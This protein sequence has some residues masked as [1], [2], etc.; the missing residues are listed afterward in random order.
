M[1]NRAIGERCESFRHFTLES[2]G[3]NYTQGE[4]TSAAARMTSDL[5]RDW[6]FHVARFSECCPRRTTWIMLIRYTHGQGFTAPHTCIC[7]PSSICEICLY[8]CWRSAAVE[9]VYFKGP[10]FCPFQFFF[11]LN[12]L[13]GNNLFALVQLAQLDAS[14][15]VWLS[16]PRDKFLWYATL[17]LSLQFSLIL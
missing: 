8:D 2:G 11:V 12:E 10:L 7:G 16:L 6:K 14:S 1:R 9:R 15:S 3:K 4:A 5:G 17:F 13:G